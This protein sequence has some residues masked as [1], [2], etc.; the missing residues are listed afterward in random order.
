MLQVN[1]DVTVYS[2]AQPVRVLIANGSMTIRVLIR[3]RLAADPRLVVVGESCYPYETR[4]KIEAL[5]PDV[6]T[7]DIEMPGMNGID[8]LEELMRLRPIPVAMISTETQRGRAAVI[9]APALGAIDCVGKPDANRLPV[10]FADLGDLL[11]VAAA[12]RL[13]HQP[14]GRP[15]RLRISIF[16]NGGYVLIRA[17]TGGVEALEA[18][19]SCYP[20]NSPPTEITQH[21]PEAFLASFAA[22]LAGHVRPVLQIA[23]NGAPLVP[24]RVYPAPG[25][26]V[27][28][29][30]FRSSADLPVVCFG[31]ARGPSTFGR[32]HVGF[33]PAPR[34]M[35]GCGV[36]DRDG[37]R[38]CHCNGQV[39]AGGRALL[40]AGRRQFGR[41]QNATGRIGKRGSRGRGTPGRVMQENPEPDQAPNAP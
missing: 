2:R 20:E 1:P 19:L 22:R 27:S 10:G 17:S 41:I 24:G 31:E 16:G 13:A 26:S 25:G 40:G 11:C 35:R 23:Q 32:C 18:I 4:E 37:A 12:A 21:M 8:F 3:S 33:G 39:A 6:L 38:W 9:E 14:S 28:D 36:S 29:R 15:L 7:L 30:C 34:S 5:N